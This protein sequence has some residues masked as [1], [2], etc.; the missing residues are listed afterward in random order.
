M[1]KRQEQQVARRFEDLVFWQKARE[2][3]KT[4]YALTRRDG[5]S[6]DYGLKN[7]IQRAA[8]SVMS[9][10]AEGF[11]RGANAE[12]LQFL[13]I[14][15]GSLSEVQS[16]L[17]VALDLGYITEDEFHQAHIKGDHVAKMMNAFIQA[18]KRT[19][20]SS[21]KSRKAHVPFSAI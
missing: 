15:K 6:R 13:F 7:Q 4:V 5:F 12:F 11:G 9:N 19:E 3:T 21:L 10:I 18:L 16:Q 17:Y 8:V 2:L 14:A 20:K 1:Q